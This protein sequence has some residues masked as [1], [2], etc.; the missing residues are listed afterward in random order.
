MPKSL[1][2]LAFNARRIG[3]DMFRF[4]T[5]SS[6]QKPAISMFISI[7]NHIN[8]CVSLLYDINFSIG[9]H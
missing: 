6:T 1:Q 3:P 5:I 2:D 8:S 9:Y 4:S 7:P